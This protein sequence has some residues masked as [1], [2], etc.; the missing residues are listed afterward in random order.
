MAKP[1]SPFDPSVGEKTKKQKLWETHTLI[2]HQNKQSVGPVQP[3]ALR[4]LKAV[5]QITAHDHHLQELS[6]PPVV[7][8]PTARWSTKPGVCCHFVMDN[9]SCQAL[10]QKPKKLG[11]DLLPNPKGERLFKK[12]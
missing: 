10:K 9:V 6:K 2:S 12:L 11:E 7:P 5:P 1:H 3:T 4:T 8:I